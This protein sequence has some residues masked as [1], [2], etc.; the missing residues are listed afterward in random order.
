MLNI[1]SL[2]KAQPCDKQESK[3]IGPRNPTSAHRRI[4][5]GMFN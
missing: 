1:F 2:T 4:A 3:E 5:T